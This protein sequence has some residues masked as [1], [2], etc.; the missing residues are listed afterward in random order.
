MQ[1]CRGRD[2]STELALRSAVHAL[3][4]RYRVDMRPLPRVRRKADI[5]FP[6]ERLAVFLDG[7]FWHGCADHYS[8]P[9]AHADYWSEKLRN[10]R[11]RDRQTDDLLRAAQWT[12]MR[13][14]EHEN[15]Q[16]AAALVRDTL[17][18]LRRSAGGPRRP[19]DV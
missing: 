12:V 19:R 4:L 11:V 16:T 14:W 17:V 6:R 8:A 18:G 3:G 7:C 10:N 9:V 13:V 2:T 1:G 15:A 5:V